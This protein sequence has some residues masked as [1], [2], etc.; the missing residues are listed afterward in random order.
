MSSAQPAIDTLEPIPGSSLW[1]DAWKRVRR[2]RAAVA[3]LVVVGVMVAASLVG[4]PAI[5][6]LTGYTYDLIPGDYELV[7]SFAHCH[8]RATAGA[9]FG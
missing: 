4:P 1:N 3:A 9:P 8:E 6:S 5:E 7:R 2:N